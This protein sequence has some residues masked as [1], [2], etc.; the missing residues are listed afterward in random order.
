MSSVRDSLSPHHILSAAFFSRESWEVEELNRAKPLIDAHNSGVIGAD[1]SYAMGAVFAAVAFLE[2]VINELFNDVVD[3]VETPSFNQLSL[4]DRRSM[5]QWW[6]LGVEKFRTLDKYQAALNTVVGKPF[7]RGLQPYQ[8]VD[9]LI[10]LRN[11]LIHYE[12]EFMPVS[13]GVKQNIA[14]RLKGKFSLNPW[15]KDMSSPFFPNKCLSHGCAEWAVT[16]SLQFTDAFFERMKLTPP[17]NRCHAGL[18]TKK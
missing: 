15:Y 7:E 1:Q 8:A 4:D 6:N 2:A 11:K 16:S 3:E 5:S 13:A 9:D 10:T 14:G 17:Y 18:A 12:P